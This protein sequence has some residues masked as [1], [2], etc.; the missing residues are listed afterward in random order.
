[1]CV[2][3][4]HEIM[5]RLESGDL[6]IAGFSEASLTPNG[7]DLRIAEISLPGEGMVR[8]GTAVV[9]PGRMIFVS[10]VERV[11]LPPSLCAQLWLRTSWMRKGLL[12]G[13]GKVDAGFKGTLTFMAVNVSASPVEVPVGSRFV[14]IVFE[15]LSSPALLTYGKRSGNYQ[16]QNGVTLAPV[17]QADVRGENAHRR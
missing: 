11:E 5:G 14:Q 17:D 2:L 10:T 8:E 16:G 12:A 1:M 4:D 15:T 6:V 13:L 9:A 3:P 7:Y